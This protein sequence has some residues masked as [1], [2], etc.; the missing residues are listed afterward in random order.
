MLDKKGSV[1]VTVSGSISYKRRSYEVL[2]ELANHK[3]LSRNVKFIL[4]GN[5][6]KEDG[7][8]FWGR[9]KAEGI[10]ERFIV[11]DQFIPDEVFHSYLKALNICYHLCILK[12]QLENNM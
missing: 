9:V 8:D 5:I 1:W 6:T 7:M 11:F 12:Y 3:K 10:E 2:M 4:F